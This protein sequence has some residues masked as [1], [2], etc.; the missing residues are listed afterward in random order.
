MELIRGQHNLKPQHRG[1]VVTLGNFDGVHLGHQ[2]V[3]QQLINAGKERQLPST[4][5]TTEPLSREFFAPDTAPPRLTRLREKLALFDQLGVDRVLCQH[6]DKA[7]ASQTAEAFVKSVLVDGL[8]MKH[9]VLGDDTQFGRNRQGD[10]ALLKELGKKY[11]FTV[12]Q[13]QT[14]GDKNQRTSSSLIRESLANGKLDLTA[15]LLGRPYHMSGR[16]AH[17]EKRGRTLGYPTA[18]VYLHRQQS[19][20]LGIFAV[21]IA[22]NDPTIATSPL[23]AVASI[24]FR[25]TFGGGACLLEVF[26]FDFDQSIYGQHVDVFFHHKLRDELRFDSAEALIEQMDLDSAQARDFFQNAFA[27][28]P[29][30]V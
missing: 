23:P 27:Q 16:V 25:P 26:I 4:V 9:I 14:I 17:G 20:L 19:P 29:T 6:F 5:F 15:K 12:E 28:R 1:S 13:S 22:F 2:H 10:F 30:N 18:N 7:F 24:G 3:L 21:T 8:G 11:Q